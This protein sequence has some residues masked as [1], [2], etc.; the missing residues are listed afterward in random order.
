M[1]VCYS[2]CVVDNILLVFFSVFVFMFVSVSLSVS[3]SVY[4]STHLEITT[5]LI[6]RAEISIIE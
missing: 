5:L 2:A 1:C 3:V 4:L 6:L